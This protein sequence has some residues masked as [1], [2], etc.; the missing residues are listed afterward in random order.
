M[1]GCAWCPKG[2]QPRM[3]WL[4]IWAPRQ[5][6]RRV[7]PPHGWL[8]VTSE[9]YAATHGVALRFSAPRLDA[10]SP[11]RATPWVAARGGLTIRSHAWRGSTN[12]GTPVAGSPRRATPW[13][14]ARGA[15]TIRSHAWRGSTNLGTPAGGSPR[16]ATPWVAARDV[17][18]VRSQ[19]WR[20]ST[21]LATPVAGSPRRATPWVAARGTRTTR[22]A[23]PV[24]PK[25]T[26]LPAGFS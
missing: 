23:L 7:E 9:R 12:L 20:G 25:K 24:P 19:A 17:R 26:R 8:H 6:D 10:G 21:I 15:R 11:R 2:T 18:T 4:R 5:E 13:V 16:R 22:D 3:A 1:G 14:A